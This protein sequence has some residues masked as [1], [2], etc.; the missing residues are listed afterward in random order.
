MLGEGVAGARAD[1]TV[2]EL[3]RQ[4]HHFGHE[5]AQPVAIK[6][7]GG[8]GGERHRV[9]PLIQKPLEIGEQGLWVLADRRLRQIEC[10]GMLAGK[11]R[12]R[13]TLH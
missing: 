4:R 13:E 7:G 2:G 5:I 6:A 9:L 12:R 1:E 3:G 11:T 10:F 8:E